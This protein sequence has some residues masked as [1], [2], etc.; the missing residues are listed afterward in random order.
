[1]Q[2]L[3]GQFLPSFLWNHYWQFLSRCL[4]VKRRREHFLLTL[5]PRW[6]AVWS[7]SFSEPKRAKE[8]CACQE[9]LPFPLF[10]VC[11]HVQLATLVIKTDQ[12]NK[13]SNCFLGDCI[14]Q[15]RPFEKTGSDEDWAIQT[16]FQC[17]PNDRVLLPPSPFVRALTLSYLLFLLLPQEETL[18]SLFNQKI[19]DWQRLS[20]W[21]GLCKQNLP[22]EKNEETRVLSQ[23]S[24]QS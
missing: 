5:H 11:L 8:G 16:P 6:Q 9:V 18:S 2:A 21:T 15:K 23:L 10:I 1:M 13:T 20:C 19:D 14:G 17:L 3:R 22:L 7:L 24:S 4:A 12:K